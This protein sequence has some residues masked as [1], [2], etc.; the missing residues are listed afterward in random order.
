MHEEWCTVDGWPYEVSN[1]GRVRRTGGRL[2]KAVPH[3]SGYLEVQLW[4]EN[5]YKNFQV[6]RLV[7]IAFKGEPPT[8]RHEAAHQN[9]KRHDNRLV[10]LKWAT[11]KENMQ[12]RDRHGTTARGERNGKTKHTTETVAQ[13]RKLKAEGLTYKQ[14]NAVTGVPEGTIYG[15]VKGTR[16]QIKG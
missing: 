13:V 10:N 1:Q 11:P 12:D 5:R 15:Y 7:L 3:R 16:R 2:R 4:S 9:G 6:Q 8:P 14:I